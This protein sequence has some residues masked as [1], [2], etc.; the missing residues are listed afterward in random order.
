MAALVPFTPTRFRACWALGDGEAAGKALRAF[1]K[2]CGGHRAVGGDHTG[3]LLAQLLAEGGQVEDALV[4]V[5]DVRA[6]G[7]A[8]GDVLLAQLLYV[9]GAQPDRVDRARLAE[10]ETLLRA[11]IQRHSGSQDLYHLL[12]RVRIAGG[13]RE[14][15]IAALEQGFASCCGT[16]GKC[17]AQ[18]P[19]PAM[20]ELLAQLRTGDDFEQ[21][22]G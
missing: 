4:V 6:S 16:P 10:A 7:V 18:T 5:R 12:A 20:E 13:Y 22:H 14:A 21:E 9:S 2:I 1:A 17:G 3:V 15:A 19:D 8:A 11:L